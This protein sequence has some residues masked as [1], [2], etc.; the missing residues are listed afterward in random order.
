[1]W[2]TALLPEADNGVGRGK[3]RSGELALRTDPISLRGWN[4]WRR[5]E[6]AT[7]PRKWRTRHPRSRPPVLPVPAWRMSP[8]ENAGTRE[9]VMVRGVE[10]PTCEIALDRPPRQR[11]AAVPGEAFAAGRRLLG[12]VMEHVPPLGR[13]IADW[14]R[15]RTANRFH[16]EAASLARQVGASWRDVVLANVSYDLMLATLG[17]STVVLPTPRGPVVARNM[18]WW[19]E[20]V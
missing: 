6:F 13:L 7:G 5:R 20:A 14:V 8:V 4:F 9:R 10:R 18:D 17:C 3:W 15:L 2:S 12:E 1:G 11:Y 19:P 16:R